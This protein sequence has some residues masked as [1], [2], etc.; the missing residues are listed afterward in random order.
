MDERLWTNRKT[1]DHRLFQVGCLDLLIELYA[2]G[3]NNR[4]KTID[5]KRKTIKIN[6]LK[7]LP[8]TIFAI[9]R[10]TVFLVFYL[11]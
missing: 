4:P 11:L 3:T 8:I 7:S 9:A 10:L 5:Q 1:K 2:I 6:I